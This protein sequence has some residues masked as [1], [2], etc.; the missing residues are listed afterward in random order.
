MT[1]RL[2]VLLGGCCIAV[3]LPA[4][5][6]R[7]E[8]DASLGLSGSALRSALSSQWRHDLHARLTIGAGLRLTHYA[9]EDASF[10]NVGQ[11]TAGLPERVTLNPNAWGLNVM[12]SAQ[13]RVTGV[14]AAGA[15]IDVAGVAIGPT[16]HAGAAE[17]TP[18]RGSLFQYGDNDRGSLN[19]EF[20]IAVT[21]SPQ[22]ELRGGMSHYV[23][24]YTATA[25]ASTTR[26]LRFE[27]VPFLGM[28]WR[29]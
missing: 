2:L 28:R 18:A 20:F 11:T 24:G 8:L 15:N 5:G 26:Y 17:L 19:S 13:A 22:W 10:R 29:R 27:T 9:G 4:S 12:V 16:E 3:A 1:R 23:V 6:Q 25:G 7:L 14:V 21:L